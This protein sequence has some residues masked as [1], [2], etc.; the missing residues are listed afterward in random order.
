M[1]KRTA[2]NN[3]QE[4]FK[5]PS[6]AH[7]GAIY[8][9]CLFL[10]FFVGSKFQRWDFN[11]GNLAT[12]FILILLPPIIFLVLFKFDVKKVL[13]LNKIRPKTLVIIFFLIASSMPLVG[14]FNLLNHFLVKILF[15]K[16]EIL[17][18]PIEDN[19][20][21]VLISVFIIGVV[22]GICEEVLFRGVIQR[23]FE[24]YGIK[25]AIIITALLF[26]LMHLDFQRLFG[27]FLLGALIGFIVYRT[28]SLYSGMFAHFANNSIAVLLT[29]YASKAGGTIE[30]SGLE[31]ELFSQLENMPSDNLIIM[32][33]GFII[34]FS[35]VLIFFG[36]IFGLLMR[37]F[38]KNTS[39]TKVDLVESKEPV[40]FKAIMTFV[41]GLL[42]VIFVYVIQ[43]YLMG[44]FAESEI[45]KNI[46]QY[47]SL[48]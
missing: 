12:Q 6:L 20:P 41:P 7:V 16:V 32:V 10:F 44:G 21:G 45:I 23:G 22:A 15:G 27:T 47:I 43:A 30:S 3:S 46:Y 26:G 14:M 29:L 40:T 31:E 33:I 25:R 35:L 38:I 17:Q 18:L 9:I 34:G 19:F 5:N 8:S 39:N 2:V 42:L 48:R 36:T 4:G 37:L 1:E 28:N 13:R 24:R 11:K